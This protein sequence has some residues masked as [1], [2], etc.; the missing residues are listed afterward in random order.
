M[1]RVLP[2]ALGALALVA[3]VPTSAEAQG[4]MWLVGEWGACSAPCGGG[5]RIRSWQCIDTDRGTVLPDSRCAGSKP[6]DQVESCNTF[7]CTYSWST[8]SFGACSASC[9]G[10]TQTRPVTC[11]RDADGAT[12]PDANCTGMT[13]PADTQ[14]CNTEPCPYSW[15]VGA[16]SACSAAC[17]DGTQTRSVTCLDEGSGMT[18]ADALCDPGSRPADMQACNDG[19]CTYSWET[20]AFGACSAACG[21]GTQT[22]SVTCTADLDGMTVADSLCDAGSRPA[23]SQSCNDGAC[24]YSWA[25]GDFGDC[26]EP[27]G[28]GTETRSVT[29][30]ADLD[31]ATVDDSLCD[32]GTRPAESQA[33]NED[34]CPM[35]DGG[36]DPDAGT[37][38]DAGVMAPDAAVSADDLGTSAPDASSADAAVAIDGGSDPRPSG[39]GCSCATEPA[40]G[41]SSAAFVLLALGLVWRRRER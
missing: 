17:G 19:A 29:C 20:G 16:L 12:V 27:C 13:R 2:F 8:G 36:V 30:T 11:T 28:G 6:P 15:Q 41:A 22:R 35:P 40:N 21:D 9:G 32:S 33:C 10:G 18:V 7:A 1:N 24:T 26:S 3:L 5:S 25:T 39:D 31:G 37:E 38:G 34:P 14:A 23:E 4:P